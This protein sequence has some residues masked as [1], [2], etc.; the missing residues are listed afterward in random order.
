MKTRSK[1][2]IE[3]LE[4]LSDC[5]RQGTPIGLTEAIKVMNYQEELKQIR[6]ENTPIK[7]LIKFC[8]S[9]L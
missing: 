7:R 8:K 6:E 5:V 4:Y 9:V 1:A 3:Y 2:Q